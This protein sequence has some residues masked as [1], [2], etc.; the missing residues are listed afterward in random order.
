MTDAAQP[1]IEE[2]ELNWPAERAVAWRPALHAGF[3]FRIPAGLTVRGLLAD[4]LGIADDYVENR[5]RTVFLG[6]RPVDD[7]DAAHV[8]HGAEM[9][10]STM[11]PGVA[12]ITMGRGNLIAAYRAD[13]TYREEDVGTDAGDTV[14]F[15]KLLN[16]IAVETGHLFIPR[17]VGFDATAWTRF[18][19][20][21]PDGFWDAADGGTL[22]GAPLDNAALAALPAPAEGV[23]RFV[24]FPCGKGQ[25]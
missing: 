16:F 9:T 2:L 25:V 18:V 10:L 3:F 15:V 21:R 17:G 1:T 14:I 19:K 8:R 23:L 6:G 24:S 20:G 12:G 4:E 11:L 13:I 5:I 7:I 22:D